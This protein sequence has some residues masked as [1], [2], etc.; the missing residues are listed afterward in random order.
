MKNGCKNDDVDDDYDYDEDDKLFSSI[1]LHTYM[2]ACA[3]HRCEIEIVCGNKLATK[4]T[5]VQPSHL[6]EC[7]CVCIYRS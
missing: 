6:C 5:T 2:N 1:V 3:M 7:V 4:T